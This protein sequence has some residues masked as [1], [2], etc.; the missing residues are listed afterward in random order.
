MCGIAGAV[1]LRPGV[2]PDQDRVRAMSRCIAHRGPDGEG[3]WTSPSGRAVLAHRRLSV[4]DLELGAQPMVT[5]DGRRG[6]VFNGEIYDYLERRAELEREGAT[7]RTRSDTEVLHELVRRRGPDAVHALRGMFAFAAW[8]DDAGTLVIAR[9]RLGKKPLYMAV[10]DDVLW[11]ASSLQ[12]VRAAVGA[13]WTLDQG[14]VDLFLSLGYVPGP[15]TIYR[16]CR[17]FPAATVATLDAS[18]PGGLRERRFWDLAAD[19]APF[20]GTYEQALDRLDAELGEAT[21]LRLRSDVPL[22]VFLSGGVDSSLIAALAVRASDAPIATFAIG[23]G[24]EEGDESEHAAAVAKHLG[25]EHRTIV[26]RAELLGLVPTLMEHFGEPYADTSAMP[27]WVLSEAA[28]PHITV[29][30]GGDGGDEG[31]AGYEWY[32]TAAKLEGIVSRAPRRALR[33]GAGIAGGLARAGVAGRA[34][35]RMQRALALAARPSMGT[36]F[37]GLRTFVTDR[38][39]AALY[40]GELRAWRTANPSGDALVARAYD[41]AGGSPLRRMRYADI[42]TYLADDLLPKVD[43]TSMAHGLEVRAPLL[44]QAVIRFGLS[45]PDSYVQQGATGKRILRDLLYRHVPRE[46]VDRPKRG[47]TVPLKHWLAGPLRGQLDALARSERLAGVGVVPARVGEIAEEHAR[48]D[49]D[50]TQL[51]FSLLM[52]DQWLALHA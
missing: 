25:T 20:E 51:L 5:P 26:T 1:G 49:R 32:R 22:G 41:A 16:E 10:H 11:F 48:G 30:L 19:D 52:L 12:A 14:A 17:K 18:A 27:Y 23:F 50:N 44:D 40:T 3:I 29:A 37:G 36:R 9:D 39:A 38:E 8:D 31:F 35:G 2:R 47:F 45:L 4:I 21:R 43:V 24:G 34:T 7:F 6:I 46:L 15:R 42:E 28:R 33:A 13:R